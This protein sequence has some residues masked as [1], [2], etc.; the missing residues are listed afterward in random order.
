MTK[1]IGPGGLEH[2][3]SLKEI[4]W[5]TAKNYII[6]QARPKKVYHCLFWASRFSEY[7]GTACAQIRASLPTV[8]P[9]G[10]DGGK[11]WAPK[12]TIAYMCLSCMYK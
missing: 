1:K 8:S 11:L 4:I 2:A 10:S 3:K 9:T 5:L 12:H 6:G 7:E